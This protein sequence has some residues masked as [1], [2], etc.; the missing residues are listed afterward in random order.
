MLPITFKE[1][2]L[3]TKS[4][5]LSTKIEPLPGALESRMIRCG[6]ANCKCAKGF[7]HGPYYVRRW[8]AGRHRSSKY[9]KKADVTQTK[10]ACL[11]YRRNR[12]QLRQ[13]IAESLNDW[14]QLKQMLK[15]I[16]L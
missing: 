15:E 12:Q 7:L 8:R 16:G 3:K 1:R 2:G 13:L 10:A 6:K 5:N 9:V 11:V 4:D 14:R